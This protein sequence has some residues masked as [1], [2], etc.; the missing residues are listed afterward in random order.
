MAQEPQ[1]EEIASAEGGP[2]SASAAPHKSKAPFI[3]IAIVVGLQLV[4]TFA[5]TEFVIIPRIASSVNPDAKAAAQGEGSAHGG[6]GGK[7]GHGA[8]AQTVTFENIVANISGTVQSRYVKVSFV[9]EGT[10]ADFAEN[11]EANRAKLRDATLGIL[12]GLTLQSL[13]QPGVKNIVRSDLLAAFDTAMH[14]KVVERLYFTD[15]V[16]Q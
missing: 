1:I 12:S 7:G 11:I 3:A 4:L 14:G 5:L 6:E 16:V 10:S 13:D 9:V 2:A 15:F 8:A